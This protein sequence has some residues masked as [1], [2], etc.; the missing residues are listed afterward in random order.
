[1]SIQEEKLQ[2]IADAIREKDGTTEPIP[3]KD[4]AERIR[5]IAT[6]GKPPVKLP[7]G[8]T[9]IEYI[10]INSATRLSSGVD[11]HT[12]QTRVVMDIVP[13]TL[14]S[15][16][17][18]LF[19]AVASAGTQSRIGMTQI[20]DNSIYC[21]FS[22]ATSVYGSRISRDM[23][24]GERYLIDV[25]A[26]NKTLKI[27]NDNYN[28]SPYLTSNYNAGEILIGGNPA[29]TTYSSIPMSIYSM[30]IYRNNVL[31]GDFIPCINKDGLVGMY[32]I[33]TQVELSEE[34]RFRSATSG[35]IVAGPII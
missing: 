20:S 21:I 31:F 14:L 16:E 10:S 19:M 1:M 26:P 8:Y 6:G 23:M 28:I 35:T 17:R 34:N 24:Q 25:D 5:A 4:F 11:M 18:S 27:N 3:A 29:Q 7:T 15:S 22:Y 32:N 9:E 30:K 13:N 33:T 12:A 2:A